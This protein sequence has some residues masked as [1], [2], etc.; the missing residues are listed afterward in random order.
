MVTAGLY[1][2]AGLLISA[3]AMKLPVPD[4]TMATLHRLGLP[5]GRA[6]ARLLGLGE[7]GLGLA[8][9]VSGGPTAAAAAAVTYGAFTVIAIRQRS[10]QVDCGCFGGSAGSPMTR[11]HIAANATFAAIGVAGLLAQPL[12]LGQFTGE[13]GTLGVLAALLLTATGTG[14]LITHLGT[15]TVRAARA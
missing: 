7:I 3:G 1:L 13:A 4:Q 6:V 10:A 15:A 9:V 5:S 14:L 11:S 8:I 2:A 12:S